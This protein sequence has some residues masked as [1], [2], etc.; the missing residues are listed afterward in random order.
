MRC[1]DC[2]HINFDRA[3]RSRCSQIKMYDSSGRLGDAHVLLQDSCLVSVAHLCPFDRRPV[4]PRVPA[5]AV[6]F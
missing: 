2:S 1:I 5:Q 6:L 4:G 3:G